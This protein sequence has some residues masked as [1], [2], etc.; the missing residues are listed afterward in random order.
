MRA[1]IRH[2]MLMSAVFCCIRS[3]MHAYETFTVASFMGLKTSLMLV[4]TVMALS[5]VLMR[6]LASKLTRRWATKLATDGAILLTHLFHDDI[7]LEMQ[8][9]LLTHA[10]MQ[11]SCLRV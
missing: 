8:K 7:L 3:K 1:Y 2:K 4:S 11:V 5:K 6:A 10:D 9:K